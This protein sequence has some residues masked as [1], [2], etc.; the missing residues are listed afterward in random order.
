ME[1]RF[2]LPKFHVSNVEAVSEGSHRFIEQRQSRIE[3]SLKHMGGCT[4]GRDSE[5]G[6]LFYDPKMV[7]DDILSSQSG[8]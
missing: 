7:S 8:C 4:R 2:R 6:K 5:M 3:A 1:H